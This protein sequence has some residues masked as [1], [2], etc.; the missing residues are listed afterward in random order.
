MLFVYIVALCMCLLMM[1]GLVYRLF[2][3]LCV[4]GVFGVRLRDHYLQIKLYHMM[5]KM[6]GARDKARWSPLF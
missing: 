3:R 2:A 1:L 4:A 5:T 6:E